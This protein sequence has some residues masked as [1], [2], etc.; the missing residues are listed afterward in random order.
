MTVASPVHVDAE[1][2]LA[3][4]AL[5]A[6]LADIGVLTWGRMATRDRLGFARAH[7]IGAGELIAATRFLG[8]LMTARSVADLERLAKPRE[9]SR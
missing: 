1:R 2:V 7:G 5:A 3:R 9:G 4:L 8:D 6:F